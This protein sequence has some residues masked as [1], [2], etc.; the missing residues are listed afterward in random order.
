[1]EKI[2]DSAAGKFSAPELSVAAER[3]ARFFEISPDVF[4]SQVARILTER[5]LEV[6][7]RAVEILWVMCGDNAVRVGFIAKIRKAS[8]R[9]Y[10]IL[11]KRDRELFSLPYQD[12]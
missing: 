3:C 6:I 11:L 1:M 8:P 5:D 4:V 9:S 7:D 12:A 2:I 10:D